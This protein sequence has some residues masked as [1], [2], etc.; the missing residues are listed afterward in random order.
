MMVP[1]SSRTVLAERR[2]RYPWQACAGGETDGYRQG[3]AFFQSP[4][5]ALH[6]TVVAAVA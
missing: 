2:S 1:V 4:N 3:G 6:R 5:G